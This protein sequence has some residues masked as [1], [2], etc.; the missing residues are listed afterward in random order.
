MMSL[1]LLYGAKIVIF[2]Y[3][4]KHFADKKRKTSH[5]EPNAHIQ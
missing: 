2:V 1:C 4:N 5:I 3:Y